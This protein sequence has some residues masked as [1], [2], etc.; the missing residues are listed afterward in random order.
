MEDK[1]FIKA[2]DKAYSYM[3]RIDDSDPDCPLFIYAGSMVSA[4]FT[5]T[6]VGIKLI[7][8]LI[9]MT[10]TLGV[11]IDGV[12]YVYEMEHTDTPQELYIQAAEG[13]E[14]GEHSITV[15][16]RTA[17]S[18][19]YFS[20]LGLTLDSGAELLPD[21]KKYDMNIEVYGDSVS[22]GEVVEA[23]YY[24]GHADPEHH[25]QYDNSWFSY[26]LSLARKLNARVHDIAQGGIALFDGTGYFNY[27][28]YIGMLSVY[29][30]LSYTP[31][32]EISDWDFSRYI[33]DIVIIA[34]G[35][36]DAN[37]DPDCLRKP[38][39]REK[40]KSSYSAMLSDIREKYRAA[41]GDPTFILITTVLMHD[42]I[43]DEALDEICAAFDD[44]KIQRFR[45]SR[46]G[47]ATPGHPR[48]PEQEEMALELS[49]YIKAQNG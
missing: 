32:F 12:Q 44:K 21:G 11:I 27:P 29:D 14:E 31:P 35:Q 41:G 19:C 5:G 9:Y 8:R 43:W 26:P 7:P 47:A 33:P 38:E 48:I 17:G 45:F 10:S 24:T 20:F 37:P 25:S 23:V 49:E 13:L 4:R 1:I 30:K 6:S 34:I 3:G 18:H 46:N 36:N 16:K 28:D 22:S 39:Y 15:F 42:P 2:S 40:W